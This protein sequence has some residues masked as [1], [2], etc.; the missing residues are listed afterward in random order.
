MAEPEAP[1]QS[2]HAGGQ[3]GRERWGA[4]RLLVEVVQQLTDHGG[5]RPMGGIR[6]KRRFNLLDMRSAWCGEQAGPRGTGK[7]RIIGHRPGFPR[8]AKLQML[9]SVTVDGGEKTVCI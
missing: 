8:P 6:L 4:E 9:W 3:G 7:P 5:E 2:V 1:I